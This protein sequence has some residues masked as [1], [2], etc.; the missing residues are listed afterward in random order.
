[1]DDVLSVDVVQSVHHLLEID[2]C[3]FLFKFSIWMILHQIAEI[4]ARVEVH[5]EAEEVLGE[6]HLVEPNYIWMVKL[7]HDSAFSVNVL[8]DIRIF[9][10]RDSQNLHSNVLLQDDVIGQHNL[11]EGAL[12]DGDG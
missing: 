8:L 6:A 9:D 7:G 5:D 11:A 3:L 1:M 2:P 12:S 4:T 10:F